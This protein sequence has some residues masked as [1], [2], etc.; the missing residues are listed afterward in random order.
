MNLLYNLS[1]VVEMSRVVS[2][3]LLVHKCIYSRP[4]TYRSLQEAF[5]RCSRLQGSATSNIDT[6]ERECFVDG[7]IVHT[8]RCIREQQS[9]QRSLCLSS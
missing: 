2:V 9:L 7:G 4:C 6:V 3:L 8:E 5:C 1:L